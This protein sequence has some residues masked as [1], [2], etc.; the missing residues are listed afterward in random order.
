M[1]VHLRGA[2]AATPRK[3]RDHGRSAPDRDADARRPQ[4]P[5]ARRGV[6]A[7]HRSA[8][9]HRPRHGPGRR[10]GRADHPRRRDPHP[11]RLRH[12]RAG[13][14]PRHRRELPGQ[15]GR[16]G[17]LRPHPGPRRR[18][19]RDRRDACGC[20][21]WPRPG[22]PSPTCPTC[23]SRPGT[24]AGVFTGGSLLYRLDRADRPARPGQHRP[25][26][27]RAVRLSPA[28]GPRTARHG[29]DLPDPRVRQLLLG[30]PV[31]GAVVHDRAGEA[32]QPR[33][34]PG[35]AGLRR[36]AAGRAGRLARLLRAHGPGQHRRAGRRRPVAARAGPTRRSCA[37]G[38]RPASG[39]S[40]CATGSRSRPASCPARSASRSTAASP[41]TWAG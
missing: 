18:R 14:V 15:R 3:E 35:R 17:R 7:G 37:A 26:G 33:A 32:R 5:G 30:H 16:P 25:A 31:A 41:P 11:Q 10:G 6:G 34:H 20:G 29:R 19:R 38:S 40:T 23:W 1:I 36:D 8:A 27:P 24:V 12:R 21:C 22:T 39:S 28:A 4:L 2:G 9:G 13:A